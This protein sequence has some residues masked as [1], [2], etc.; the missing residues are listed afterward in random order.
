MGLV[1]AQA[2]LLVVRHHL[3][4]WL[5][6]E[7][8]PRPKNTI[9]MH[10]LAGNY[11]RESERPDDGDRGGRFYSHAPTVAAG[12]TNIPSST[13][14]VI[15]EDRD[16]DRERK[17]QRE[18]GRELD[19]GHTKELGVP[20]EALDFQDTGGGGAS[21]F[22]RGRPELAESSSYERLPHE[23]I[24]GTEARKSA[25]DDPG[26]IEKETSRMERPELKAGADPSGYAEE[27]YRE[28]HSQHDGPLK[29]MGRK[30][31]VVV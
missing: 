11:A 18:R 12:A 26:L 9:D 25:I 16:R 1:T 2:K 20:V 22:Y 7:L 24:P 4:C 30:L 3:V 10:K 23:S 8:L 29:N 15:G 14:N 17:R 5:L 19:E 27:G 28:P 13:S 6:I 31:G 21:R